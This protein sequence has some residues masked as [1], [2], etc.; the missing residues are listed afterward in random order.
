MLGLLDFLPLNEKTL[1]AYDLELTL[2]FWEIKLWLG[3]Y[4]E[5]PAKV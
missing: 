2:Y 3:K 1:L 5:G 4:T